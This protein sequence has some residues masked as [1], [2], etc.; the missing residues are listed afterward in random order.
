MKCDYCDGE[1]HLITACSVKTRE[2]NVSLGIGFL[3]AALMIPF[4]CVGWLSGIFSSGFLAGFRES[5]D[6]WRGTFKMIHGK[7]DTEDGSAL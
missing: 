5:K 7:K 6:L 4:W 2:R 3:F 1:D